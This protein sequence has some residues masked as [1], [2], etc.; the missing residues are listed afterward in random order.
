MMMYVVLMVNACIIAVR[1][2]VP[3]A[4]KQLSTM[5]DDDDWDAERQT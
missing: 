1:S 4:P 2:R 3:G 5:T